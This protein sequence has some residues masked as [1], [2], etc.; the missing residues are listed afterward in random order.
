MG[1]IKAV[2]RKGQR[3]V[4][5]FVDAYENSVGNLIAL[6]KSESRVGF[7]RIA[8]AGNFIIPSPGRAVRITREFVVAV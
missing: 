6:I 7:C 2:N 5:Y 4:G 8:S 1:L 3:A